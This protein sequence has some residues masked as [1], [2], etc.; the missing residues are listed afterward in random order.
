MIPQAWV[1]SLWQLIL[2]RLIYGTVLGGLIPTTTALIRRE[3]PITIQGE[4]MGYNTSFRFFGNIFGPLLGGFVS[5]LFSISAVF[6][7]TAALFLIAFIILYFIKK[8]P[9]VD[10]DDIIKGRS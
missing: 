9:S 10:L 8:K 7:S 6:Y 4:V 3:A 1:T 5:G 2:L